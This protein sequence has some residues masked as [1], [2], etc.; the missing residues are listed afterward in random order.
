MEDIMINFGD[1]IKSLDGGKIGGYLVLFSDPTAPDLDGDYF[2]K[3]TDFGIENGAKTAVWFHH[4]KPLKTKDKKSIVVKERIGDGVLSIDDK[5]VF[6]ETIL[7]NR[8]QYEKALADLGWSSGTAAHLTDRERKGKANFVKQWY[9]GLDAS[10]TPMPAEPATRVI[11]L[12]SYM[13]SLDVDDET[14]I[15]AAS[16]ADIYTQNVREQQRTFWRLETALCESAK[17]IANA[18]QSAP[19]TGATVDVPTLC[20]QLGNA[21]A[22]DITAMLT[23]QISDY[24]DSQSDE[25][26]Y[27]KSA[28]LDAVIA[29]GLRE[30]LKFE[31]RLDTVLAANEKIAADAKEISEMRGATK[32]GRKISQARMDKLKEIMTELEALLTEVDAGDVV[33]NP[34]KSAD[35]LEIITLATQFESLK[36]RRN[37]QR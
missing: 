13:E 10:L 37:A 28:L 31:D 17:D 20:Q 26:F 6:I 29:T 18:A 36:M 4:R 12:K 30:G 3:D 14:P 16:G 35:A 25:P 34:S 21:Y 27:L 32:V 24:L 33:T 19:I 22:S 2:T 5:G 15:K 23:Q 8:K 1:A 7:Y 11:S 9:L